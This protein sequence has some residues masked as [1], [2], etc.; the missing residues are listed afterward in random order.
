MVTKKR[1]NNTR[2]IWLA[3]A[4]AVAIVFYLVHLATRSRVPIRTAIVVRSELKSTIATNGK[5]EPQFNFEAH[6]PFAGIVKQLYVHEGEKAGKGKLLLSMDDTDAKARLA[7]AV[8][9]LRSA[10]AMY[11][12]TLKG[13]SRQERLAL[14]GDLAKMQMDRDQAQHDVDALKKLQLTGAASANEVAAAIVN[15]VAAPIRATAISVNLFVI[16]ALGDAVSP[17]LIGILSD[18]TNLRIGLSITLITL[19]ASGIILFTGARYAP[20]LAEKA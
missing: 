10:Q 14:G 13:G 2:W 6:A 16:H 19:T 15:S 11:D 4:V 12:A 18:A 9:S 5:V 3:A 8:A 20:P 1:T 17:R 7:A